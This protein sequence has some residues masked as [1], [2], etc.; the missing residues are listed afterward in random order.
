MEFMENAK[1]TIEGKKDIVIQI[2]S[3]KYYPIISP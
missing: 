1:M 2:I 3:Y